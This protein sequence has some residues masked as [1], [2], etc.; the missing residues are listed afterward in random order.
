MTVIRV[1]T[2]GDPYVYTHTHTHIHIHTHTHRHAYMLQ[3]ILA[4][5]IYQVLILPDV[6]N[7]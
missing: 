1:L 7:R 3:L 4:N 5:I 2:N 6:D